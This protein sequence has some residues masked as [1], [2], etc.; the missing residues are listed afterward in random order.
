MVMEYCGNC[1]YNK[2]LVTIGKAFI[3]LEKYAKA[4]DHN[5]YLPNMLHLGGLPQTAGWI[6]WLRLV[7]LLHGMMVCS[8]V[9]AM[10]LKLVVEDDVGQVTLHSVNNTAMQSCVI[11]LLDY[12]EEDPIG[13]MTLVLVSVKYDVDVLAHHDGSIKWRKRKKKQ[14]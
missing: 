13:R 11:F 7:R 4:S 5:T 14:L 3:E 10:C 9:A 2:M 8:L 1:K 12:D 6:D